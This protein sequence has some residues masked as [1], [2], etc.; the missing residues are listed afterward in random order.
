M[1]SVAV[2]A[3]AKFWSDLIII[4]QGKSDRDFY[5]IWVISSSTVSEMGSNLPSGIIP[6]AWMQISIKATKHA[7]SRNKN[8]GWPYSKSEVF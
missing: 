8:A 7:E 4:V 2:M 1:H 5:D 6:S 3:R